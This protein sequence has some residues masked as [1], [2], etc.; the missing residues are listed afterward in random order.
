[1]Y[2]YLFDLTFL[3]IL[4]K[5]GI[6]SCLLSPGLSPEK[7]IIHQQKKSQRQH[8]RQNQCPWIGLSGTFA[9]VTAAVSAVSVV[10]LRPVLADESLHRRASDSIFISIHH[11]LTHCSSYLFVISDYTETILL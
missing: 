9:A 6:G 10:S 5:G 11:S 2:L 8:S 7:E 1:M 3:N 4:Q